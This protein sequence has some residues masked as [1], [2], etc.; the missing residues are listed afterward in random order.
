ITGDQL[1][2]DRRAFLADKHPELA[3]RVQQAV[4]DTLALLDAAAPVGAGA[5]APSDTGSDDPEEA[6]DF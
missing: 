1:V 3:A 2:R 4:Q 5:G 6:G